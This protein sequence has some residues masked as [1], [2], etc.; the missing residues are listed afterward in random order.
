MSSGQHTIEAFNIENPPNYY[1]RGSGFSSDSYISE[2]VTNTNDNI[3]FQ[4]D[5]LDIGKRKNT[6]HKA[7]CGIK[8]DSEL[9][10]ILNVTVSAIGAGCFSFPYM[11]YEGGIIVIIIIFIFVTGSVYYTLD[12]LRSF[13]VDT[14]Y[15]SFALMTETILGPKWLKVYAFSSFVIYVS[16]VINILTSIHN[17]IQEI[18]DCEFESITF[19]I[20]YFSIT[21]IIEI[22]ICLYISKMN[23]MMHILSIVSITSFFLI[24]IS[25][26]S[27]AI[28]SNVGK[29]NTKF[30]Y[31]NLFFPQISSFFNRVLKISS[32]ITEYVYGYSYH[33]TFPT[34]LGYLH[35]VNNKNTKKVHLVSFIIVVFTYILITFFGFIL[36]EIVPNQLF[37]VKDRLFDGEWL[38]LL[39]PFQIVMVL[40]FLTLIPVRFLVVRDNYLT[41]FGK[42][43]ITIMSELVIITL[44]ILIC[45]LFAF[46]MS[47]FE[48]YIK[49]LD[50]RI[51]IQAFGGMFGFI[52]SFCL[53]VINFVSVNGKRK[54]KSI[55]GYFITGF[56]VIVGFFSL[57]YTFHKIIFGDDITEEKENS[58]Q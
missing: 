15:F 24:V 26:I 36:S 29:E 28:Y 25:L 55:I 6:L 20:L 11:M 21:I 10:G 57:Y 22:I 45:N 56:Y 53:P 34:I 17:Y 1:K 5:S 23:N 31:D 30:V 39:K 37:Q 12:L 50:I 9:S 48:N 38:F 4:E 51:L 35:K 44:F 27:I 2:E 32:Y 49:H 42:R 47:T 52:I 18:L 16:M 54:I 58:F 43:K 7:Y 46:G 3:I 13:V 19:Q 41:L 14:K 40:F 8:G 33:S